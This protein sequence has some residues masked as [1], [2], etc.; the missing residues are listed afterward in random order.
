[1]NI[2]DLGYNKKYFFNNNWLIRFSNKYS[3]GIPFST[4]LIT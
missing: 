4:S 3:F 2:D 1:V